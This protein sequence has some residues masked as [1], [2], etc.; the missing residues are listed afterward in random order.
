M[1]VADDKTYAFFAVSQE[2]NRREFRKKL[3][4]FPEELRY[5]VILA[6]SIIG[7]ENAK[8]VAETPKAVVEDGRE[9]VAKLLGL[10]SPEPG[11]GFS[12]ILETY[13]IETMKDELRNCCP[14]CENFGKCLNLDNLEVGRLFA[15]RAHGEETDDLKQ[16]IAVLIESALLNTPHIDT[17]RAHELCKDFSHQC[18]VSRLGEVFGR[19]SEIAAELRD[20]FG[21]DYNKIQQKMISVNLEFLGKSGEDGKS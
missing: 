20:A 16:E 15:R 5:Y 3:D 21:I 4:L 14:N 10:V 2:L 9:F 13:L 17:D 6:N 19:Y 7:S 1:P 8:R 18:P 12:E 11:D